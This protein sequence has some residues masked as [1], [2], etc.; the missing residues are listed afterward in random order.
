MDWF[1]VPPNDLERI[2][3]INQSI[4]Q[5]LCLNSNR[6]VVFLRFLP[7]S[8]IVSTQGC[9]GAFFTDFLDLSGLLRLR[10]RVGRDAIVFTTENIYIIYRTNFHSTVNNIYK[11]YTV[12]FKRD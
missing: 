9:F 12:I 6:I 5:S 11:K 10:A 8:L 7:K 2:Q 1:E 4:N 3:S